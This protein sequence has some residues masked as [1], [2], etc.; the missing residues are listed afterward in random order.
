MTQTVRVSDVVRLRLGTLGGPNTFLLLGAHVLLAVLIAYSA[1]FAT[2]FTFRFVP[3]HD[4]DQYRY[5]AN[6]FAHLHVYGCELSGKPLPTGCTDCINY[7]GKAYY[8]Y[9]PAPA[10][11]QLVL[12]N[13]LKSRITDGAIVWAI[14]AITLYVMFW[15]SRWYAQRVLT[16]NA[17][18]AILAASA[19]V[20]VIGTTDIFLHTS[21]V[22]YAW[23]EACA[24]GQLLNLL[25]AFLLIRA[26]HS[27]TF[28]GV[29]WSGL[30]AGLSFLCKQ[31]YLPGFLA[32]CALL[33]WTAHKR[34]WSREQKIRAGLMFAVP[35][36]L[37]VGMLLLYNY[38][39]FG[40]V[41]ETGFQYLN[42]SE[43]HPEPYQ[44][45]Q[46][47]RIP[48]NFYN[49]F[50]AGATIRTSDFPFVLGKSS[51]F[52]GINHKDGSGGLLHN[53][54]SFSVFISMPML[55]F[56]IPGFLYAAA[57]LV[58]RRT[59]A[60]WEYFL[61]LVVLWCCV[62]AYFLNESGSFMRYQYDMPF[63]LGLC[64]MQVV[65]FCWR[66][67]GH[68]D[69]VTLRN[70]ARSLF[71]LVLGLCFVEQVLIGADQTAGLIVS[72]TDKFILW[73]RA[74]ERA[75]DV[76]LR[77]R[78]QEIRAVLFDA[79]PH[80]TVTS[81]AEIVPRVDAEESLWLIRNPSTLY[82]SN[83]SIWELASGD[84]VQFSLLFAG[85]TASGIEPIFQFG[86]PPATDALSVRYMAAD[87]VSFEYRHGTSTPCSSADY[88]V[89][90]GIP[91]PVSVD[92]DHVFQRF[93]LRVGQGTLLDCDRGVYPHEGSRQFWGANGIGLPGVTATFSGSIVRDDSG[94]G[95]DV[96]SRR[97]R[98]KV[99]LP[100]HPA[101]D[102]E[103]LLQLGNV[104]GAADMLGVRY[105][106][107][108]QISLLFDHW[109]APL[110]VSTPQLPT[111][112]GEQLI[113]A[114]VNPETGR[115]AA[116]LNGH[117]V[118]VCPTGVF[119]VDPVTP[120]KNTLG[121]T[122][123]ASNFSGSIVESALK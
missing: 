120:G 80:V 64:V 63:L 1:A 61:Y 69:Q 56:V 84:S 98:L 95:G 26:L 71:L 59:N 110:C 81:G 78:A 42:A 119:A 41:L 112:D 82:K 2:H 30:L 89:R 116:G 29:L 35:V 76:R 36:A 48:F 104:R 93:R 101:N 8:P 9:G 87:R 52:G 113:E 65:V 34:Q 46:P 22:P 118:M 88:Q 85:N 83:G 55:L 14:C 70:A 16:L 68:I 72:R 103:P 60:A 75:S 74:A 86:T 62:F 7:Y 54:P 39:R 114:V 44:M 3:L 96:R 115:V 123:V 33:A 23:S 66:A 106:T 19:A 90:P 43:K 15:I 45:P 100:D 51:N 47:H 77:R 99:N 79:T 91:V 117:V 109:T 67:M 107:D 97:F 32:G 10:F 53:F 73:D 40:S 4:M 6:G 28:R 57:L 12:I 102:S 20:A 13:L 37:C 24:A 18:N 25:S 50:L 49:H 27:G 105:R 94:L 38:E 92:F 108:G 122:T 17:A 31:N 58:R 11:I 21:T 111:P 121:F 5:L